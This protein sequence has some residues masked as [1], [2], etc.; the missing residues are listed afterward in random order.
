MNYTIIEIRRCVNGY[1]IRHAPVY[2][3]EEYVFHDITDALKFAAG[4]LDS[5][6]I[7]LIDINMKVRPTP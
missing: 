6:S 7:G 3:T 4:T 1:V 5:S 2:S